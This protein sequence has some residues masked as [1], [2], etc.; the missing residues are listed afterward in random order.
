[1]NNIKVTQEEASFIEAYTYVTDLDGEY[2]SIPY[3]FKKV[4]ECVYEIMIP[5][6]LPESIKDII[7]Q[8]RE[9]I[10]HEDN[11]SGK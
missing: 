8:T 1:M 6:K 9:N 2:Y 10:E 11:N 5:D 4:D 3:W 7:K